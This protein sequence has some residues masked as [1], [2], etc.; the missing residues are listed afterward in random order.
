[1][2]GNASTYLQTGYVHRE[3]VPAQLRMMTMLPRQMGAEMQL[4]AAHHLAC[5]SKLR[6]M[7][8][9]AKA[10]LDS[11]TG[12]HPHNTLAWAEGTRDLLADDLTLTGRSASSRTTRQRKVCHVGHMQDNGSWQVTTLFFPCSAQ[13]DASIRQSL[14]CPALW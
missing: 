12:R 9:E 6:S 8:A 7:S 3:V 4:F 5:Q 2:A 13:F 10:E 11:T 14:V 1:M